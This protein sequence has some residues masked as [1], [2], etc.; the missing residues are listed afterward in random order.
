[1]LMPKIMCPWGLCKY[2]NIKNL[3]E[4]ECTCEE[5]VNLKKVD[6]EDEL[7]VCNNFEYQKIEGVSRV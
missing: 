6:N 7:I 2:N 1:M 4:G 3:Y 5:A